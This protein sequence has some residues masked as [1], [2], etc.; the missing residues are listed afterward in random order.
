MN[1][2]F[3]S[4]A[5]VAAL[6][7][8]LLFWP[9]ACAGQTPTSALSPSPSVAAQAPSAVQVLKSSALAALP[10]PAL[11]F[12]DS[13]G[14][15]VTIADVAERT[16]SS[17]VAVTTERTA[18]SSELPP[19]FGPFSGP[20]GGGRP[21][22][23]QQ[24]LGSGVVVSAEG[25][26]LTN[27]HVVEGADGVKITTSDNQEYTA[28]VVGTDAK[29]DLA[30]LRIQGEPK[31]LK[32]ITFGDSSQLR[33]GDVVLAIGN[34]FGV[35]QTV[36][37]GIVSAKGRADVGIVD[38]EDFIQ[39][40]AAINPGNSGGAL[41]NMR[42]ELVGVNT[43]ILS[44]SGGYQG[45]GFAI[46]TNMA[47]PI[48]QSLLTD[49]RVTRGFLGI[50]IQDLTPE[51]A[52]AMALPT[53]EGVLVSDVQ[54]GG[55][56]ALSGIRRGDVILSVGGK[57]V[58]SS[59]HLR[60]L[61][62]TAGANKEVALRVQRAKSQ[63]DLSVKLGELPDPGEGPKSEKSEAGAG[64]LGLSLQALTP[65][66]ASLL[67]VEADAGKVVIAAV[68]PGSS[69]AQAGLRPGDLLLELDGG[70]IE[71][72]A[73]AKKQVARAKDKKSILFLV[74]R[75]DGSRFIVVKR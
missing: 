30:V 42:G 2:H 8:T 72:L 61:I 41:V 12:A 9:S 40:D 39:T 32:P 50:G 73:D 5:L 52:E 68:R 74:R 7:L 16:V 55:A 37:M 58:K 4:L 38:Y 48:L 75:G 20:H 3:R 34:P 46:P 25:I 29:S 62:A 13:A 10:H 70:K 45:I 56:A 17:V 15:G 69:A 47:Q 24:G 71:N 66:L 35:G 21:D 36:T 19:F 1:R 23:K 18:K 28:T 43:A 54:P 59:G 53:R 6:P 60:N 33:L 14:S 51:I 64:E 57:P 63:L 67:G 31:G 27:N 44:R 26:V 22:Q 65:E 49:G 11:A